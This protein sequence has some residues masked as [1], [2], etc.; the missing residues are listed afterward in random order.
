[1]FSL[2]KYN[3]NVSSI[4]YTDYTTD[5]KFRCSNHGCVKKNSFLFRP[6]RPALK[7]TQPSIQ[8]VPGSMPARKRHTTI[9]CLVENC[10]LT[11]SCVFVYFVFYDLLWN[12][13][14]KDLQYCTKIRQ[15]HFLHSRLCVLWKD[16]CRQPRMNS[17]TF[18]L[19]SASHTEIFTLC[20]LTLNRW[21]IV[22]LHD[23]NCCFEPVL[24]Y[25]HIMLFYLFIMSLSHSYFF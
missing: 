23:L 16:Y 15:I 25:F 3:F 20:A 13:L 14:Q 7:S 18:Y 10:A 24:C 11:F 4:W 21:K 2:L 8:R 22:L 17:L 9:Y 12:Y 6:P 5:W 1:V 19:L